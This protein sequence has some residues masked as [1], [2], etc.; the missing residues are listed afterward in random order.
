MAQLECNMASK[1]TRQFITTLQQKGTLANAHTF[2]CR[3]VWLSWSATWH[4]R[5]LYSSLQPYNRKEL[6]QMHT[7]LR[8]GACGSAGVQ[9]GIKGHHHRAAACRV[10]F[11]TGTRCV[12]MRLCVCVVGWVRVCACVCACLCLCVNACVRA[13]MCCVR[14][15]ACLHVDVQ[16]IRPMK[17]S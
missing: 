4:L 10:R 13:Y 7:H 9:H 6:L 15:C 14:V 2:T 3:L 11:R 17:C 12:C 5:T 1:D 8:A 16:R